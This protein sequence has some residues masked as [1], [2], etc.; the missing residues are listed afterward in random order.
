MQLKSTFICFCLSACVF[1]SCGGHDSADDN[2]HS[3]PIDSTSLNGEPPAT[4]GADNPANV[5]DTVYRNSNDTATN[6]SAVP[7]NDPATRKTNE[8]KNY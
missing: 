7:D 6:K 4:Y 3:T 5:Q 1:A 2:A 8:G